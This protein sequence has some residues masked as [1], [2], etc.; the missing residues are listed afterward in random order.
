MNCLKKV[1]SKNQNTAHH[2]Y[3]CVHRY[4]RRHHVTEVQAGRRVLRDMSICPNMLQ[5]TQQPHR[6]GGL[7]S[8]Q[9]SA[10]PLKRKQLTGQTNLLAVGSQLCLQIP[11]ACTFSSN[12]LLNALLDFDWLYIM[13]CLGEHLQTFI[14]YKSGTNCVGTSLDFRTLEIMN[15][16]WKHNWTFIINN[17]LSEGT[18][19]YFKNHQL[20][21]GTLSDFHILK[22][23]NCLTEH[24][25]TSVYQ[26][27]S[28]A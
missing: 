2:H 28:T 14:H 3:V 19:S 10:V 4:L 11:P 18:F 27:S 20:S 8:T 13:K 16:M 23:V 1:T 17:E 7:C 22:I 21:V 5:I 25:Q 6:Q 24:C 26:K 15:C 9:T 12:R